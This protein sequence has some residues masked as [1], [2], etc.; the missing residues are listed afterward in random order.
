M[1]EE[2]RVDKAR[3]EAEAGLEEAPAVSLG[4]HK[5][6][7]VG[8]MAGLFA[9][10]GVV[11]ELLPEN[12]TEAWAL[13]VAG[14]IAFFVMA[15]LW[16]EW[17]RIERGRRRWPKFA[18]LMIVCPGPLVMVPVYLCASRGLR[19]LWATAKAAAL[20]AALLGLRWA[21]AS[22]TAILSGR[23]G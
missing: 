3:G 23:G 19:G 16:C 8:L 10:V 21:T 12:S 20:L 13:D 11:M 18:L 22:A 9:G 4:R 6:V 2:D 15:Y 14:A 17:D 5:R 1:S 7:V